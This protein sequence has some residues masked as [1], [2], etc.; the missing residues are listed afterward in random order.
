[1]VQIVLKAEIAQLSG[2]FSA[3]VNS[4][5]HETKKIKNEEQNSIKGWADP[6]GVRGSLYV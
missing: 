3:A 2:Q 5:I 6:V 1:M 4:G